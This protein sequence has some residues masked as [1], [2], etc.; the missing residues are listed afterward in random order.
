MRYH[1]VILA[2]WAVSLLSCTSGAERLAERRSACEIATDYAQRFVVESEIFRARNAS[3]PESI[4]VSDTA[5]Q[6]LPVVNFNGPNIAKLPDAIHTFEDWPNVTKLSDKSVID[7]CPELKSWLSN[8]SV[9]VSDEQIDPLKNGD[10]WGAQVMSIAMPIFTDDKTQAIVFASKG[11]GG[12]E[13]VGVL[14]VYS[15]NSEGKWDFVTERVRWV[16]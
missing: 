7:N 15:K 8:R 9:L 6:L 2:V 10:T 1:W 14:A 12:S 11:T 5:Y 16:S 13:G 3:A 4:A